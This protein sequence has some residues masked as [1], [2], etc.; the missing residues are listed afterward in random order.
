MRRQL[1]DVRPFTRDKR[2][3]SA[4]QGAEQLDDAYSGTESPADF[5]TS[6]RTVGQALGCFKTRV[7]L[8]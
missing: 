4:R 3:A 5:S 2:M 6:R 1:L 7:A 8:D